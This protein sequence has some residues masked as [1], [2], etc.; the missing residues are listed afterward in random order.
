MQST[1]SGDISKYPVKNRFQ[2]M[3]LR[4]A[5][6]PPLLLAA[7]EGNLMGGGGGILINHKVLRENIE[8]GGKIMVKIT[9]LPP[10]KKIPPPSSPSNRPHEIKF[11]WITKN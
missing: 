1:Y 6:P 4:S 7:C 2:A 11:L 5:A 8:E 10:L 9:S 3:K